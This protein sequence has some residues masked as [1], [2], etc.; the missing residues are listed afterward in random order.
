MLHD[1]NRSLRTTVCISLALL[2]MQGVLSYVVFDNFRTAIREN[3]EKQQSALVATLAHEIDDKMQEHLRLIGEIAK[4]APMELQVGGRQ[5]VDF[6]QKHAE[7]ATIFDRDLFLLTADGR[8]A[9]EF[10]R[11]SA[12]REGLDFSYRSQIKEVMALHKPTVSP[13]YASS[14]DSEPTVMFAAPILN[15]DGTLR[16]ILGGAISLLHDNFLGNIAEARVGSSG[17]LYLFDKDRTIVVHPDRSRILQKDVP[18]GVNVMFD[19]AL[20]GFEGSGETENSRGLH[21]VAA[22]KRLKSAPWI[23]AAN[24]PVSE[25]YGPLRKAIVN[26]FLAFSATIV[27]SCVALY[28]IARRMRNEVVRGAQAES[29]ASLLLDSVGEGVLGVTEEG[30][31]SFVN[32]GALQLLGYD[33]RGEL[34]GRDARELLH[35]C[36]ADSALCQRENCLLCNALDGGT[37]EHSPDKLLWRKDGSSFV[38]D[39]GCFSIR[40]DGALHGAVVTFRDLTEQ[41]E[42]RERLRLQG[43]ALEAAANSILITDVTETIIWANRSF[44]RQTGYSLAEAVGQS[45]IALLAGRQDEQLFKAL[46]ESISAKKAWHGEMLSRRKDGSLYDEDVTITPLLD[47][48]GEV[49][50]FIGIMQDVTE[51]KLSEE[52]LRQSNLALA[53]S[54]DRL[55]RAI[56][57]ARELAQKAEQANAAKSEFLAN[58]SHEIRTPMNAIIGINRLLDDTELSSQQKDY[59]QTLTISAEALMGI[60][61]GIL[62]FSKI[63]AG[64]LE[65]D[66]VEFSPELVIG[67][68][69]AVF[70]VMAQEKEIE[71]SLQMDRSVPGRLVGDPKRLAQ[72]LNNL[73]GNALKFTR[74]GFII[75]SVEVVERDTDRVELAFTVQD[76]GIGILPEYQAQLFQAFTQVDGSITRNYGGTG[77]GLAICKRLTSLM[78]GRIWC[79]SSPGIGS[80][81]SLRLPFAVGSQESGLDLGDRSTPVFP[82]FGGQRILLVEDNAFNQKVAVALLEKGGLRVTV[83]TSG[84]EALELIGR[85]EFDLVLMDIQMPGMDGLTVARHIRQLPRPGVDMLPILAVSA[86]A[87]KQDVEKSLAA[88]M[89]GHLAKPFTPES[90][91]EAVGRLVG[92]T[93]AASPGIAAPG[94]ENDRTEKRAAP[95]SGLLDVEAGIRQLG[96]DRNLYLDLLG[97]FLREYAEKTEDVGQE[98]ARGNLRDAAQLAHS[99]RGIAGVLA[100]GPLQLAAQNLERALNKEEPAAIGALVEVF[101]EEL[102][103]TLAVVGKELAPG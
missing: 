86:N 74:H 63:E 88:G 16:G 32:Q 35:H 53:E 19:R 54:N 10:P 99:V 26:L 93:L 71:L 95:G 102:L 76:S 70:S 48:R 51:R 38:A 81:F 89:N 23:L 79:E 45:P 65:I 17:Y 52:A 50:H 87:M 61:N 43:A 75:L 42:T 3:L 6:L 46:W 31:V 15:G 72:I 58:M 36:R 91:Y 97:R 1:L 49:T 44:T 30:V 100:A 60:I 34:L 29:Y 27:A 83:A 7:M 21:A 85:L 69:M 67:E 11:R 90:L 40:R 24:F 47:G 22:F 98:V 59:L 103:A 37:S 41:R 28:L 96:G 12:N 4:R 55:L 101:R 92:A 14:I 9:A 73:L 94:T 68:L 84:F 78:G 64:K 57:E 18:A 82:Q 25:A 77:L 80:V 13:P 20:A 62:D 5:A 2:C 56:D 66:L 39:F 33:S 8:L